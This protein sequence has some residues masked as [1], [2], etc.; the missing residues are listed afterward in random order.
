MFFVVILALASGLHREDAGRSNL[1]PLRETVPAVASEYFTTSFLKHS[2]IKSAAEKQLSFLK[3]AHWCEENPSPCLSNANEAATR[4]RRSASGSS[5]RGERRL[6][7]A[8]PSSP[9]SPSLPP[10]VFISHHSS[11]CN[12]CLCGE[13]PACLWPWQVIGY[14]ERGCSSASRAAARRFINTA[15]LAISLQWIIHLNNNNKKE[16]LNKCWQK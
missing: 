11:A 14:I 8:A 3:R 9:S 2:L 12:P 5:A 10:P 13:Y 7:V 1:W 16:N 15:P 6:E 4:R